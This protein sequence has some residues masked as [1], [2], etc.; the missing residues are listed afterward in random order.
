MKTDDGV[1]LKNAGGRAMRG[2][3]GKMTAQ[4]RGRFG[5]DFSVSV[6]DPESPNGVRVLY[7]M[8]SDAYDLGDAIDAVLAATE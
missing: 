7:M 3:K 5:K 2:V 4:N 6:E 8:R 1:S